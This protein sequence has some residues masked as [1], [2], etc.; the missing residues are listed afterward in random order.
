MIFFLFFLLTLL[1][2]FLVL[3][4]VAQRKRTEQGVMEPTFECSLQATI[5][6][7]NNVDREQDVVLGVHLE[8]SA[9]L[10]LFHSK[11]PF[12]QPGPSRNSFMQLLDRRG[13]KEGSHK[14]LIRTCDIQCGWVDKDLALTVEASNIIITLHG[15]SNNLQAIQKIISPEATSK[16]KS[17]K[18]GKTSI[19]KDFLGKLHIGKTS[20]STAAVP[21]IPVFTLEEAYRII[22]SCFSVIEAVGLSTEGLYRISGPSASIKELLILFKEYPQMVVKNSIGIQQTTE[23]KPITTKADR[24]KE[25]RVSCDE[26]NWSLNRQSIEDLGSE[27]VIKQVNSYGKYLKPVTFDCVYESDVHL[28]TGLIKL[29][30]RDCLEITLFGSKYTDIIRIF[31]NKTFSKL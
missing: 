16:P 18:P 2:A 5:S 9:E 11:T 6:K 31:C 7:F 1:A 23:A 10:A 15:A 12:S 25:K 29:I 8:L 13:S 28:I 26:K 22:S 3:Y 4:K 21:T 27:A 14:L 17:E 19:R 30:L 20:I 24:I